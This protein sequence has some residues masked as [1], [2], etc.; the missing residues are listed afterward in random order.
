MNEEITIV[1]LVNNHFARW[2]GMPLNATIREF[3]EMMKN[4][5]VI[6][7]DAMFEIN[8][9]NISTKCKNKIL[10]FCKDNDP[11]IV[12]RLFTRGSL[13]KLIEIVE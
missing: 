10:D 6:P 1:L 5:Y 13:E 12:I 7:G 4:K 9:E 8:N 3:Y 2:E 11:N